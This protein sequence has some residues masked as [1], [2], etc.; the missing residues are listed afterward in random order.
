[1]SNLRFLFV[2]KFVRNGRSAVFHCNVKSLCEPFFFSLENYCIG[3]LDAI[4]EFSVHNYVRGRQTVRDLACF[5]RVFE[6]AGVQFSNA[7]YGSFVTLMCVAPLVS[8]ECS[9]WLECIF[10]CNVQ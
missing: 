5:N 9:V 4:L 1:M 6:M 10:H 2:I 8:S 3:I 7:L